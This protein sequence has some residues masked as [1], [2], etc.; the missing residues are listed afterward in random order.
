MSEETVYTKH[1][2]LTQASKQAPQANDDALFAAKVT[3][4]VTVYTKYRLT[5]QKP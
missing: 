2:D 4:R 5:L 3:M 1:Q